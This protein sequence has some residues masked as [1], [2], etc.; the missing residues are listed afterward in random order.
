MIL[1][2]TKQLPLRSKC[3]ASVK[4]L[5]IDITKVMLLVKHRLPTFSIYIANK[6][7]HNYYKF[8]FD[9]SRCLRR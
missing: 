5:S 9:A 2:Q 7:Y 3:K 1:E 6:K 8:H 4:C